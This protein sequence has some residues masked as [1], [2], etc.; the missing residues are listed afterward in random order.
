MESVVSSAPDGLCKTNPKYT[1]VSENMD[2][3]A[4][5]R[6]SPYKTTT[7]KSTTYTKS[8]FTISKYGLVFVGVMTIILMVV[9]GINNVA[10]GNGTT[11]KD[12]N[13]DN[14]SLAETTEKPFNINQTIGQMDISED[15]GVIWNEQVSLNS[16]SN[17]TDLEVL[18]GL[19]TNESL[20]ETTEKP[21]N[22]NRTI[23]QMDISEDI[24][25]IWNEQV[26]STSN[27]TDLEVLIGLPTNESLTE[28]T[29]KPFNINQTKK[30]TGVIWYEQV[31]LNS[32]SN[33]TDLEVLIGLPTNES[34][35]ETSFNIS[36][37]NTS[38]KP[39]IHN[40]SRDI[41]DSLQED[42][43]LSNDHGDNVVLVSNKTI[44][45]NGGN[46]SVVIYHKQT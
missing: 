5:F 31:S 33:T 24:G 23:G 16:T 15:I 38:L 39:T 6:G 25:V 1:F 36:K 11:S 46:D 8:C 14:E 37:I 3:E 26:S 10:R 4:P 41:F 30:D 2:E 20:T 13:H 29:E 27:T 17:T 32:T 43:S 7:R 28:T 40:R 22:I 9:L 18:I 44:I 35:T 34:L 45:I 19:P 21:F 12:V 42:D